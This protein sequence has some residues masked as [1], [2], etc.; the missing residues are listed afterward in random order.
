MVYVEVMKIGDP[1]YYRKQ[2]KIKLD[3][4]LYERICMAFYNTNI[5]VS[6]LAPLD[7]NLRFQI[8]PIGNSLLENLPHVKKNRS[9]K[10]SIK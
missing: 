9:L 2:S 6:I 8:V 7:R 10:K 5:C 3:V 4:M 1:I